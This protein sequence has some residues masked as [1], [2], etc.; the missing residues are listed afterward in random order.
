MLRDAESSILLGNLKGVVR[1]EGLE[2]PAYRF[3]GNP[4]ERQ[5]AADPGKPGSVFFFDG[6]P[7]CNEAPFSGIRCTSVAHTLRRVFE[8][9]SRSDLGG[10]VKTGHLSTGKTGHLLTGDR[11]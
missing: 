1:P 8:A 2:P 5:I 9:Q 7:L 11:D 3:E 4:K 6:S 10:R